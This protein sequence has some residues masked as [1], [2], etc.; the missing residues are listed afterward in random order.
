MKP[1]VIDLRTRKK[2][3]ITETCFKKPN[4]LDVTYEFI[5]ERYSVERIAETRGLVISTIEN[6]I[7]Q[8]IELGR[9]NV[10]SYIPFPVYEEIES[11]LWR[12]GDKKLGE[13]QSE[14]SN[15]SYFE[16]KLVKAELNRLSKI[17]CY[18]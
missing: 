16:L 8:L 1:I 7:C 2:G 18:E 4:T 5:Q 9:I 13:I 17:K 15:Y 14:H 10:I 12:S 11:I 3:T 6:H